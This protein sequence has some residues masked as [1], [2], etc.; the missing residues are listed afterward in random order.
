MKDLIKKILKK[1]GIDLTNPDLKRRLRIINHFN[2]DTLYDIGA[3]SGQ[4]AK[5]MRELGYRNRIISFEPLKN[6]FGDLINASLRDN[7][8]IVNNYAIGDEDTKSAINIAANSYSSSILKM[9]PR[10]IENAPEA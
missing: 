1:A 9:L 3:I 8:W 7:D 4:Y 5:K 2:I 6:A 10:L